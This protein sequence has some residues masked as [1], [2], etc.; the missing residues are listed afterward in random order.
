RIVSDLEAQ[1]QKRN[2]DPSSEQ[3]RK[4]VAKGR[5]KAAA[6]FYENAFKTFWKPIGEH[7]KKLAGESNIKPGQIVFLTSA[8]DAGID[9]AAMDFA[10][11]ISATVLNITPFTYAEWMDPKAQ[12]PL[13]I[14]NSVD[15]Y[16]K[17]CAELAD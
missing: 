8:S 7:I 4:L 10:A 5:K 3:Y 13:Y 15:D 9:K 1:L 6:L 12:H 11:D 16:A 17:A 14:T 2:L